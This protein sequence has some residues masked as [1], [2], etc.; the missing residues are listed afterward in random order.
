MPE[1]VSLMSLWQPI[2]YSALLV[3]VASSIVWMLLPHHKK[4]WSPVPNEPEIMQT[5]RDAGIGPG[6]YTVPNCGGDMASM[7]SPEFQAKL[8]E[9]PVAFLIVGPNGNPPMGALLGKWFVYLLVVGLFV[10]YLTSLSA[11]AGTDY[12]V[13]FRIASTTAFAAYSLALVPQSIWK[14]MSWSMTFKEMLDGLVYA[15]LTGGVF[16]ACWPGL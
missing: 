5:L 10:A 13:V 1:T 7:K 9:G 14:S 16:G 12:R 6:Q 15:L 4:D 2:L 8:A 3:F 11:P